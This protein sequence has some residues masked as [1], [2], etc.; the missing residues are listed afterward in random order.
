MLLSLWKLVFYWFV[1]NFVC[2]ISDDA[3]KVSFWF[4]KIL[5]HHLFIFDLITLEN[6]K[7]PF[8][9]FLFLWFL[10]FHFLFL[11][12]WISQNNIAGDLVP[13][14][15]TILHPVMSSNIKTFSFDGRD[16]DSLMGPYD[17]FS[18]LYFLPF[19][20]QNMLKELWH[21]PSHRSP[22]ALSQLH[23]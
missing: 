23:S 12:F 11:F 4:F 18:I 7:K 9:L 2:Y 5:L 22:D 21:Q 10:L 6:I 16:G 3:I 17:S 8:L 14:L 1:H 20:R 19:L 15:E 13:V